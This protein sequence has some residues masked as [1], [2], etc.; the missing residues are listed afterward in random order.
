MLKTLKKICYNLKL[1]FNFTFGKYKVYQK[2]IEK[3][4]ISKVVD[5]IK[6]ILRENDFNTKYYAFGL[7]LINSLQEDYIGRNEFLKYKNKVEAFLKKKA[8]CQAFNYDVI[9]KDKFYA[10]AIFKSN[11]I[12]SV[13]NIA[14]VSKT[15]ILFGNGD[16]APLNSIFRFKKDF[17]LKN[18][19]LEAG[20]GVLI[21]QSS[22][23]KIVVNG[24]SLS[25][26]ELTKRI[27]H[28][29]WVLQERYSSHEAIRRINDSALNTTR[30]V[31]ILNGHEPMYL[32]GF[33]SFA[34]NGSMT[35]GW[36]KG[37]ICV[38][39][40]ITNSC[41]KKW[42]YYHPMVGTVSMVETHPG[43][44][45]R[46]EG[47]KI[48]ELKNVVDLCLQAHRLLYFNFVI[49]WDVA[50]TNSGSLIVEANE[51]PGMNA[52]QCVDGGLRAII[53]QCFLNATAKD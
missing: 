42:G 25:V 4:K 40:D 44:G 3:R 38:G 9:T 27:G 7:N 28:G 49:G 23:N 39:I 5:F 18:T 47:Y 31:T 20:E 30:I 14:L 35:D 12:P 48:A 6:W 10:N 1:L 11:G 16:F 50:I 13:E 34:T 53:K 29:K 17:V 46:F 24:Q 37:S 41:L 45:I 26:D 43:S 21:C 15:G 8:N 2:G 51:K 19:V 22:D 32:T 52:V 36:D 33:Q